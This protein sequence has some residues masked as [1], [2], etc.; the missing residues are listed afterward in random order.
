MGLAIDFSSTRP[1][2]KGEERLPPAPIMMI[3]STD[4]VLCP[5]YLVNQTPNT[6]RDIVKPPEP[7][8]PAGQR[9]TIVLRMEGSGVSQGTGGE[10]NGLLFR[11]IISIKIYYFV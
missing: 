3:L 1:F 10:L 6:T 5:F 2:V 7:L 9:K 8:P 11:R 4:G